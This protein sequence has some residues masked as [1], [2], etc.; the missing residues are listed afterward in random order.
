MHSWCFGVNCVA[1]FYCVLS[2]CHILVVHCVV[3]TIHHVNASCIIGVCYVL[4]VHHVVTIVNCV[5]VHHVVTCD[6]CI[7]SVCC[8]HNVKKY[9]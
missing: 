9:I 6:R 8:I 5:S 7:P 2:V 4:F 1:S 3:V